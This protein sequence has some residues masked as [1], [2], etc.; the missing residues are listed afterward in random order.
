MKAQILFTL[1][2][3]AGFLM[4]SNDIASVSNNKRNLT[5]TSANSIAAEKVN[6]SGPFDFPMDHQQEKHEAHKH[7]SDGDDENSFHFFHFERICR[8]N[9]YFRHKIV[10]CKLLLSAIHII[11]FL[12]S[13]HH[14]ILIIGELVK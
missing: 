12:A 14:I 13:C 11:A 3:I 10:A 8:S 9:K 6:V 5:V 1:I 7:S 2:L 4:V